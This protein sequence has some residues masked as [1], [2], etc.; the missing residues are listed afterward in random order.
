[1]SDCSSSAERAAELCA[2][3]TAPPRSTRM[4]EKM[5]SD[6]IPDRRFVGSPAALTAGRPASDRDQLGR[7]LVCS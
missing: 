3:L 5:D 7:W 4:S 6:L 2:L 1:M